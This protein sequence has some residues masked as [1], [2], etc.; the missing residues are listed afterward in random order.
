MDRR[1]GSAHPEEGGLAGEL[2]L[3]VDAAHDYAIYM[4]DPAGNVTLW[5]KG[6]ERMKGWTEADVL[7]QHSSLFYPADQREA[8]KPAQDLETARIQ[9]RL[10][11]EAW[12]LRKDGSEFLAHVTI[13]PLLDG[14]GELRGFSKIVRD[15]T[16]QRAIER[17][18]RASAAHLESILSTVPDAM[19]VIDVHGHILSFSRTA[20]KLFGFSEEEVLG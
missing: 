17:R 3:L 7:G 18:L 20:E 9:G 15:V 8:G 13:A 1:S 12:R 19:V 11:E 14:S 4:L 10:E 2:S 16:E 5:N 6:A